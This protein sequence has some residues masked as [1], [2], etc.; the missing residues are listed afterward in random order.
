MCFLAVLGLF[1]PRLIL[2]LL[3]FVNAPFV[4]GPFS[5]LPP[6]DFVAPLIGLVMFW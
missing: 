6:P 1:A 3:W 5:D 4:L 2:I